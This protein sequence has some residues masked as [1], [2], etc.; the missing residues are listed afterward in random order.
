MTR[1]ER[2]T[3]VPLKSLV[4]DLWHKDP[5]ALSAARSV[6]IVKRKILML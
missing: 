5:N 6:V 1:L 2:E 4:I 3:E